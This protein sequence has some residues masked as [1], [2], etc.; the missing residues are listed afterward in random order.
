M[1]LRLI[2]LNL[3][4]NAIKHHDK[5]IGLIEISVEEKADEYLIYVQDDGPGIDAEYHKKIF[6]MFQTLQPRDRVE[7]SGMGLAIAKKHIELYGG[8]IT[9]NSSEGGGSCFML[10]LPKTQVKQHSANL[11]H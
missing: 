9:V 1:P 11:G 4:S 2:L 8:S 5:A 7:G 6:K 3:V 10:S